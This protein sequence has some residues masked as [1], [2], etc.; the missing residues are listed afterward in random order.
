MFVR[1]A[2]TL[3]LALLFTSKAN[4]FW[5]D[6]LK[7]KINEASGIKKIKLTNYLASKYTFAH[8]DTALFYARQSQRLLENY[9]NDT[10]RADVNA[11][12]G[13]CL[14][15]LAKYDSAAI[16]YLKAIELAQK[17]KY[18]KKMASFNNGLGML[19]FQIGDHQ[20]AIDYMQKA[21]LL[22]FED[23]DYVNYALVNTNIA[24]A[25]QRMG[26]YNE[27]RAI[28]RDSEFRLKQSNS[29]NEILANIYNMIGAIFQMEVNVDSAQFYYEKTLSMLNDEKDMAYKCT[30]YANLGEILAAK[31]KFAEAEKNL[32][33]ALMIS[34][35]MA[36]PAERSMIYNSLSGLY[37]Q[38]KDPLKA[39]EYKKKYIALKDSIFNTEK[40]GLIRDIE[41][42]YEAGQKDLQIKSQELQLQKEKTNR[43][44]LA[45]ISIAV[46]VL[47]LLFLIYVW[48]NKRLESKVKETKERFFTNVMHEIRTPLSMIR[49][50]LS[51]LK[52]KL[53]EEERLYNIDLADRN[54]TRLTEL[55]DQMLDISKFNNLS[56]TLKNSIG[57]MKLFVEELVADYERLA[58][59][60]EI[61][62]K[63][64]ITHFNSLL[65]FDKDAL[66]KIISNLLSNAIKYTKAGGEVTFLMKEEQQEN[67]SSIFIEVKDTGI[68]IARSEQKKLFTRFYRSE[69]VADHIKGIGIGLSLVKDLV[70]AH[71]GQISFKSEEGQGTTF[72]VRL[73]F[74][75]ERVAEV[76]AP[77]I[78]TSEKGI[79]LLVEDNVDLIDFVGSLFIKEGF[80]VVKASNGKKAIEVL[81]DLSPDLIVSDIMMDEMDGLAFIKHI[82]AQDGLDHIPIITLSAKSSERS[83]TEIMNAGAQ[84]Y[85]T[86]PFLP[87]ELLAVVQNQLALI[88]KLRTETQEAIQKPDLP[89]EQKFASKDPYIQKLFELI[90]KHYERSDLSVEYL[91]DLMATNRSHF[92]RKVKSLTGYSP[93]DLIKYIRLEKAKQFLIDK[94]GNVTEVAYMCGF[95]T[96]SYFTRCFTEHFN[97]TPSEFM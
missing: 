83:K 94:K 96:Q 59:E 55:M 18:R 42:K 3:L 16:Y 57:D 45:L 33:Q 32:L 70:A 21:A 64:Q 52:G 4:C 9:D 29:S 36:R 51:L 13:E 23:K 88:S 37:E 90:F 77:T 95:S 10:V 97:R 85:L 12:I 1:C 50:P 69:K 8:P 6:S 62:L 93:S 61:V 82:K 63:K 87:Q 40:E 27:A 26:R 46:I 2:L 71:Q 14:M 41:G 80:H 81:K 47:L 53:N 35:K 20:K 79:V 54:A 44:Q 24:G 22:K 66:H 11:L 38:M 39:L 5:A 15:Y 76:A 48:F 25:M 75:R 73:N 30:A 86:K 78:V 74:K 34:E 89:A 43:F 17:L 28:L 49:G 91:A 7:L 19:F 31:G 68:G 92:Q 56:Y 67:Q 60:K 65:Y 84:V 58:G 72:T